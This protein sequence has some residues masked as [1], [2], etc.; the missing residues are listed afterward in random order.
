MANIKGFSYG[1]RECPFCG[2]NRVIYDKFNLLPH[3]AY[4]NC[5]DCGAMILF[6]GGMKQP[7]LESLMDTVA[8]YNRRAEDEQ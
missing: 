5:Q 4:I 8:A 6:A 7:P 2:S 1:L 3:D